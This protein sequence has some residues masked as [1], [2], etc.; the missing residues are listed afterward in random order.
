M[1][2]D[3]YRPWVKESYFDDMDVLTLTVDYHGCKNC[4][5]QIEPL[6]A[7]EWLERGG[8]GVV[9]IVCPRWERKEE[10]LR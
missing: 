8:D 7:C 1:I 10:W 2:D 9:H 6:R 3:K 5:N 4:K